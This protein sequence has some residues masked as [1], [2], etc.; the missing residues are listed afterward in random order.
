MLRPELHVITSI[1]L[2]GYRDGNP[3]DESSPPY[4]IFLVVF[5]S[6]QP[7]HGEKIINIKAVCSEVSEKEETTRIIYSSFPTNHTTLQTSASTDVK[8]PSTLTLPEALIIH[9]QA[10]CEVLQGWPQLLQGEGKG[11]K[12]GKCC[13]I[14]VGFFKTNKQT[15]KILTVLQ[16]HDVLFW[17]K[18]NSCPLQKI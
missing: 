16:H 6:Y 5:G 2:E 11:K 14:A 3:V 8:D 9:C 10:L 4:I 7:I 1:F 12:E 17:Y 15:K 13:F 18:S